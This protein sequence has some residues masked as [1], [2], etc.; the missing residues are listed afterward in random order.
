MWKRST[1]GTTTTLASA[2]TTATTAATVTTTVTTAAT[3]IALGDVR[4]TDGMVNLRTGPGTTRARIATLRDN[5]RLVVVA[6][7]QDGRG[8]WWLKVDAGNRT[9][10]VAKWLTD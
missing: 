9:G 7:A 5:V 6:K 8:R 10:W 2:T 3:R 1:D 4:R